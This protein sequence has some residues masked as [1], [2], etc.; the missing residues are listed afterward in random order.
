[1]KHKEPM[2]MFC[3]NK[4]AIRIAHIVFSMTGP[5]T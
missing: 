1:V 4:L 3:D 2:V 5:S